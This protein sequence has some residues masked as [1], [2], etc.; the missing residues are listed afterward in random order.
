VLTSRQYAPPVD[1]WACG[2]IIYILLCGY[3]PFYDETDAGLFEQ[4]KKG[5]IEMDPQFW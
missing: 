4:I 1:V 5:N 3:P 2:V